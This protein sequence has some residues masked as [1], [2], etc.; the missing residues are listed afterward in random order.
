MPSGILPGSVKTHRRYVMIWIRKRPLHTKK[1]PTP[2]K[3]N[4]IP[5]QLHGEESKAVLTWY[6]LFFKSLFPVPI[7]NEGHI[8]HESR[9]K[10]QQEC[11]QIVSIRNILRILGYKLFPL[12]SKDVQLTTPISKT[13]FVLDRNISC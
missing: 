12:K 8:L 4:G 3:L 6:I 11:L 13:S 10:Y 9:I 2:V 5:R 7:E 1:N